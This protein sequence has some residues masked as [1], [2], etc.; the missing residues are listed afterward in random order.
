MLPNWNMMISGF[1]PFT[2]SNI[3]AYVKAENV[4]YKVASGKLYK[5]LINYCINKNVLA[6][7]CRWWHALFLA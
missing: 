2:I 5:L 7:I 3:S 4:K 6:L 1:M